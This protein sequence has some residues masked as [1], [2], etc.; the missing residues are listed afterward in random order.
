MQLRD[1]L[2]EMEAKLSAKMDDLEQYSRRSCVRI[3]GIAE[4]TG[5]NTDDI[6]LGLANRLNL[7]INLRDIDRSHRVGPAR[8]T[9]GGSS[10]SK[11]REIIVKFKTSQARLALL[12][13]RATLRQNREKIFIN[14]DLT[15]TRKNLS[16]ECRQLRRQRKIIKTWV[17][18]GNVYIS[19]REGSKVKVS[20][21]SE[22]DP[23][24]A[25]VA[26]PNASR[27]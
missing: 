24:K 23:Y 12:K 18:N 8:A 27:R 22:L 11:P 16:Y 20:H 6:V 26:P 10:E 19:D 9:A 2:N 15:Q 14:E 4:T 1:S 13:G 3:A 5:E 21:I 25:A 17:Y 7:D